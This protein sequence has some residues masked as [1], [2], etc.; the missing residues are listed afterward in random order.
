MFDMDCRHLALRRRLEWLFDSFQTQNAFHVSGWHILSVLWSIALNRQDAPKTQPGLRY[1]ALIQIPSLEDPPEL[2]F[3][4]LSSRQNFPSRSSS[5]SSTTNPLQNVIVVVPLSNRQPCVL[6]QVSDDTD[7][8][9]Q[10]YFFSGC[11]RFSPSTEGI[12][13]IRISMPAYSI[14]YYHTG[15]VI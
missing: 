7:A 4:W 5:H 11:S 15:R 6:E 3:S 9:T 12:H 14:T 2:S 13:M 10:V 1:L 8:A